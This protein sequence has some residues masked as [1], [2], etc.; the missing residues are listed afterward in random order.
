MSV[1]VTTAM[2]TWGELYEMRLEREREGN[3]VLPRSSGCWL[4]LLENWR[5][6][7]GF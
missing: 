2:N 4:I 7:R 6:I 1:I 5:A 3:H